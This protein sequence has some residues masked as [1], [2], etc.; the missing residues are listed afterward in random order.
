[1]YERLLPLVGSRSPAP[2]AQPSRF[3]SRPFGYRWL[4]GSPLRARA[5]K[6]T[7]CACGP[8]P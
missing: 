8:C 7:G 2:E 3:E 6:R 1:M 4:P 5:A